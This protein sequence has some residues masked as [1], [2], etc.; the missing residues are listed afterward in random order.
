MGAQACY[1]VFHNCFS[2]TLKVRNLSGARFYCR[3]SKLGDEIAVVHYGCLHM[4]SRE[5]VREL[6]RPQAEAPRDRYYETHQKAVPVRADASDICPSVSCTVL[7][8]VKATKCFQKRQHV[9]GGAT[10]ALFVYSKE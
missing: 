2:I 4:V 8:N 10:F 7:I 6:T 3:A 1:P 9:C 5:L